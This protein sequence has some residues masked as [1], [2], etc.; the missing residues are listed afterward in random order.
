[1]FGGGN[2]L[3]L[4]QRCVEKVA[5]GSCAKTSCSFANFKIGYHNFKHFFTSLTELKKTLSSRISDVIVYKSLVTLPLRNLISFFKDKPRAFDF[6]K[7]CRPFVG[8]ITF[9]D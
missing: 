7:F 4:S 8:F 2:R 1:M 5:V 9:S 3:S 6:V